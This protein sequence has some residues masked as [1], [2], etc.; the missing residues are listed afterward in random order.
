MLSAGVIRIMVI[1]SIVGMMRTR[2]SI[3]W[4]LMILWL[5]LLMMMLVISVPVLPFTM[6]GSIFLRRC[7]W[8]CV[9]SVVVLRKG[10][11]IK[12]R[13]RW[14]WRRWRWRRMETFVSMIMIIKV[15]RG[16]I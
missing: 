2:D 8:L 3:R 16:E 14:G 15:M 12:R 9:R 1:V 13:R 11:K 10:G 5:V 7:L 4:S 6:R